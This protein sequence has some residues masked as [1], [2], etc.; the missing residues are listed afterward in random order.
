MTY[1]D[2][3]KNFDRPSYPDCSG[4]V[5]WPLIAGAEPLKLR[6]R[7]YPEGRD[8]VGCRFED[9]VFSSIQNGQKATAFKS[10]FLKSQQLLTLN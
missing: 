7:L 4:S 9:D 2:Y 8:T 5:P 10:S 3:K 1:T 6:L